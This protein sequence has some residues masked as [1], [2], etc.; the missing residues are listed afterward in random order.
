MLK[1]I[2]D[3]SKGKKIAGGVILMLLLVGLVNSIGSVQEEDVSSNEELQEQTQEVSKEGSESETEVNNNPFGKVMEKPVMNGSKTEKIGTYAEV[4]TGGVE[5][6]KENLIAF[7]EEVVKDSGYNWV[8]LNIDGKTGIVFAGST[9]AFGYGEI[10][11]E[12]CLVKTEGNGFII[13]DTVE[14]E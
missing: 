5:I 2:K 1:K 6:N 3:L 11:E 8:T 10:D 13:G 4:M 9:Y 14:Y 12:G 7:Y